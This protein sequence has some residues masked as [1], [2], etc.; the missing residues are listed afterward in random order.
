[1]QR[2]NTPVFFLAAALFS[3][4]GVVSAD[5]QSGTLGRG[6]A[7]VDYY[8]VECFDVGAGPAD[9]LELRLLD[10]AAVNSNA[11]MS[12]QV[13]KGLEALNTTDSGPDGDT[14]YSPW[15]RLRGGEGLYQVLVGKNNQNAD[16]YSLEYH[17]QTRTGQHAG[18]AIVMLQNR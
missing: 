13:V 3:V 8:Q 12:A 18:T 6:S 2:I 15:I 4:T 11:V 9:Y 5:E 14:R 16:G 1:M 10:T 17:C 7:N